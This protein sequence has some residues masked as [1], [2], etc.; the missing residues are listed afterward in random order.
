VYKNA[1]VPQKRLS[2]SLLDERFV[3]LNL[4]EEEIDDLV[5]FLK[6]GLYDPELERYTP[7]ALP[8][9]QCFPVADEQS[10]IDLNCA[11]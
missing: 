2:N 3:P 6:E 5:A 1:A 4:N 9:G 11:P 7:D 10:K 8:S